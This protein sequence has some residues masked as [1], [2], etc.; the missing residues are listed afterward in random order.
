MAE[1]AGDLLISLSPVGVSLPEGSLSALDLAS[2]NPCSGSGAWGLDQLGSEPGAEHVCSQ[3][4]SGLGS[5]VLA[6]L[7]CP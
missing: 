5:V 3:R 6:S 1:A 2:E 4:D 7:Q